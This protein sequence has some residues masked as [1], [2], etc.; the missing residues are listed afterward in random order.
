MAF[1]AGVFAMTF[2][3]RLRCIHDPS[4]DGSA[5]QQFRIACLLLGKVIAL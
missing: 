1:K 2:M 4:K 5:T 3:F